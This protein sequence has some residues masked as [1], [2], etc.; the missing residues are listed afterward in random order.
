[1]PALDAYSP[2]DMRFLADP[3]PQYA[4]LRRGPAAIYIEQDDLWVVS[5][6][7]HVGDALKDP[8]AFSSKAEWALFG[9]FLSAR[10]GTRPDVHAIAASQPRTLVASDPPEH[11]ILRRLPAQM[12]TAKAVNVYAPLV[13]SIAEELVDEML[14][15][16]EGDEVDL[17]WE[18]NFPLPIRVIAAILGIAPER[19][20]DFKRWSDI[21]I[22]RHSGEGGSDDE[23]AD[24]KAMMTFFDE[25]IQERKRHPGEDLISMMISG[26]EAEEAQLTDWDLRNFCGLLLS[27][28]NETTT[29]L[30]GNLSHAFF[31]H[32]DELR[33]VRASGDIPRA[34]EEILRHDPSVQA[35]PRVTLREVRVG[36]TTLPEGAFVL[37]MTAAANRDESRWQN[38]ERFDVER[39][40][41]RHFGFG[42]G[43]HH[44]LGAALARLEM[45]CG[46]EA[47]LARTSS[48]EPT[49]PPERWGNI[50]LRGFT[51]MPVAIR[52]V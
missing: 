42:G 8:S 13:Q 27:A 34:V 40:E 39:E 47:L 30:L 21:L 6:Y 26:N 37:L 7:D 32:P 18:F 2:T 4:E 11:I 48:V 45:R 38:P 5:R 29:N 12:F 41:H 14:A 1:M 28:G 44:C 33:K 51:A 25:I 10:P 20:H 52:A 16:R 3:Y 15:K 22:K 24:L 19:W 31:H 17:V 35:V 9:G 46:M 43:I 49:S 23:K 50:V 36:D